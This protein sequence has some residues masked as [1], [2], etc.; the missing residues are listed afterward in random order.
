[1]HTYKHL[2]RNWA[3]KVS[4]V[5]LSLALLTAQCSY[6][7]YRFSSFLPYKVAQKLAQSKQQLHDSKH[8]SHLL[9]LD[10]RFN[11]STAHSYTGYSIAQPPLL[12][13]SAKLTFHYKRFPTLSD[14][15]PTFWRGPPLMI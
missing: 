12:H 10:K 13:T 14:N 3:L 7:F 8:V 9:S 2:Y 6:K 11:H 5:V 15:A 1:M 4:C